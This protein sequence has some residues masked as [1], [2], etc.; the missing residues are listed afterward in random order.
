MAPG[1]QLY[2]QEVEP[3]IARPAKAIESQRNR[4]P[5]IFQRTSVDLSG[6]QQIFRMAKSPEVFHVAELRQGI[7]PMFRT[8]TGEHYRARVSGVAA[9]SGQRLAHL[10]YHAL[11]RSF[12]SLTRKREGAR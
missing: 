12:R 7:A 11:C 4:T 1:A 6:S 9:Q 8:G 5:E 2:R 10:R 3:I